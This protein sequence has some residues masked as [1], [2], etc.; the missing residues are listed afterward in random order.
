MAFMT[1]QKSWQ[2]KYADPL[3]Q[4]ILSRELGCSPTLALLLLNRGICTVEEAREFLEGDLDGLHN[5]FLM[6]DMDRAVERILTAITHKEK[7]MVYGDYDADGITGTALLMK[8]TEQ[9]GGNVDYY[10]PHRLHEG[11]GLHQQAVQQAK[12]AGF[13]LIVTVDCGISGADVVAWANEAGG[14]DF[15]ITDHHHVAAELP[16]AAAVI[17]PQRPDCTYPFR[18]LAGVGVALKLAQALLQ[19][20]PQQNDNWQDYLELAC[21]GTVADVVPLQGENRILV[22]HGL[23]YLIKP[24]NTGLQALLTVSGLKKESLDPK[25]VSFVLVPRLNATGRMGDARL[26]VELLLC[27][28]S[29]RAEEIAGQ[30]EKYNRQRQEVE[31]H[32]FTGVQNVLKTDPSLAGSRVLVA[33]DAGWHPGVTGIVAARLVER[34]RRP[35]LLITVEEDKG[36]GSGRSVPGFHL[37]DA[38]YHCRQYLR[39]FGGHAGAAGF[40]LEINQLENFRRALNEYATRVMP[41]ELLAPRLEI[42]A[43]LSLTEVSEQLVREVLLLSPFGHGNPEPVLGCPAVTVARSREVGREGG[44]LK[45]LLKENGVFLEGIGFHLAEILE[46]IPEGKVI[47]LAFTPAMNRWNG[48]TRVQLEIKEIRPAGTLEEPAAGVSPS[49]LDLQ[50]AAG[51]GSSLATGCRSFLNALFDSALDPLTV[52]WNKMSLP[53]FAWNWFKEYKSLCN[54]IYL[55]SW[56]EDYPES[57]PA[58]ASPACA[59]HA[60][61]HADRPADRHADRPAMC[62]SSGKNLPLIDL[63]GTTGRPSML[64]SLITGEKQTL[65]IVDCAY[66]TLEL[67]AYLRRASSNYDRPVAFLHHQLSPAEREAI[68]CFFAEGTIK[69]L[70]TTSSFLPALKDTKIDQLMVYN[71][72]CDQQEWLST[73][74]VPLP[75]KTGQVYLLFGKGDIKA[76]ETHLFS[77]APDRNSL[78]RLYMLTRQLNNENVLRLLT[79]LTSTL[80]KSGL[81]WFR[82]YTAGIGLAVFHEL[83]LIECHRQD[84]QYIISLPPAPKEKL[85]LEDSRTFRRGQKMKD[86]VKIWQERLLSV[87]VKEAGFLAGE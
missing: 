27:K 64:A 58:C 85:N 8:V 81:K 42:E 69:T 70:V 24:V 29:V 19:A 87:P 57:A 46:E 36:K 44:H 48:Q 53:E 25:D 83:G 37:Y 74:A 75:E 17:N 65:I 78:A 54:W 49:G 12:K 71:L 31:L 41:E 38:L 10:I 28:D 23:K 30:L 35:V 68:L 76:L 9:L 51:D 84:D 43:T 79:G 63:R 59:S 16:A 86:R 5:P 45:L 34:W 61:R 50:A 32:V 72:P 21:V 67:A 82:E 4:Y 11:Y 33:A 73:L 20:A 47:D 40:T 56:C 77:L 14:P 13:S 39:A 2:V 62:S 15:V 3:L 22:K 55:P 6:K 7:I 26:A 60:D 52:E 80:Q 1:A 18:N 66:R